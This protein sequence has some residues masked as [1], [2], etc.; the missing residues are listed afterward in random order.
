MKHMSPFP[1]TPTP[2]AS[3]KWEAPPCKI[4]STGV[5]GIKEEVGW[6][7]DE[8][9][10]A[11]PRSFSGPRNGRLCP[12]WVSSPNM[13]LRQHAKWETPPHSTL[14]LFLNHSLTSAQTK[15]SFTSFSVSRKSCVL[16]RPRSSPQA[17]VRYRW[18]SPE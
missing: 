7:E 15:S 3:P 5:L 13:S 2:G 17:G 6:R 10:S 1:P 16:S 14:A 4:F 12:A 11:I 9:I 8:D 18:H